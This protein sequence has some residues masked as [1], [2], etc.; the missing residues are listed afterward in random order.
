M[1][2][3]KIVSVK[4]ENENGR[5][6]VVPVWD[7]VVD[8]PSSGGYSCG[9]NRSIAT[10]LKKAM[11]AGDAF[12]NVSIETDINGKTYISADLTLRMRCANADLAAMGH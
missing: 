3:P 6:L 7:T 4:I 2:I 5:H 10:R 8:R 9:E 12:N 1:S 11:L